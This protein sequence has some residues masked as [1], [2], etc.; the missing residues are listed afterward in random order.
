MSTEK[1]RE[2]FTDA[3]DIKIRVIQESLNSKNEDLYE[4]ITFL[5]AEIID[6]HRV[7]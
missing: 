5:L 1:L 6:M 7:N 3:S 2:E 4:A